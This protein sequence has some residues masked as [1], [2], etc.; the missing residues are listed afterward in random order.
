MKDFM[1][2]VFVMELW[3]IGRIHQVKYIFNY[4]AGILDDKKEWESEL[5]RVLTMENKQVE[6]LQLVEFFEWAK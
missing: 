3:R 1:K 4:G 2:P 5:D 6:E